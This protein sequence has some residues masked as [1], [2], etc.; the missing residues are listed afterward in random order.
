MKPPY[1]NAVVVVTGASTGLGRAIAV[2]AADQ[3]ARAVVIN[4]AS[5]E[6]E[7]QETARQVRVLGAESVIVQ[8][9]VGN[10]ADCI[11]IAE[12]AAPFGRIDALFCNAGKTTKPAHAHQLDKLSGDDFLD[13]YRVNVVGTFQTVRACRHLL[14][15]SGRAA[16][17]ATSSVAG[18]TG[19]GSSIAYSASKA[20]LNTMVL[21]LARGLAPKIRI[22]SV[23]PG[24]MDTVWFDKLG[25]H[26][27]RIRESVIERTLLKV[28]STPEDIAG[29]ALFLGSEAACRVT[30]ET[31]IA[32]AGLR[33]TGG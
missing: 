29:T 21:S 26:R 18:V 24:F 5:S 14:E 2:G 20:A 8:G 6:S 4:F 1:E 10:D 11:A 30:G 19:N 27:D 7:A 16:I 33:M 15:R 32:D 3:G 13:V 12:A 31:L 28:A 22:N 23:A 25:P 9:D 17:V